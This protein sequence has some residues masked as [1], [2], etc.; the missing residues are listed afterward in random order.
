[1]RE[2][3]HIPLLWSLDG[4]LG[5]GIP[6]EISICYALHDSSGIYTGSLEK[7]MIGDI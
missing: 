2:S 1:M 7:L 6:P 3:W 5:G 4:C